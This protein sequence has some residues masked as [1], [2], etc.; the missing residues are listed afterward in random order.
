M[1]FAEYEDV[2]HSYSPASDGQYKAMVYVGKTGVELYI[3]KAGRF[4]VEGN[5]GLR[6]VDALIDTARLRDVPDLSHAQVQTLLGSVG[7]TKGF[8]I[9]IPSNDRCGLD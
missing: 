4:N 5:I 3:T 9:W 7:A 6:I 1:P 8:D 2:F